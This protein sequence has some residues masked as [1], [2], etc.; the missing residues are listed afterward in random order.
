MTAAR[1]LE[2]PSDPAWEAFGRS[3]AEAELSI[4]RGTPEQAARLS[5]GYR[6]GRFSLEEMTARIEATRAADR[7]PKTSDAPIA[8]GD[9]R[10]PERFWRKV[11]VDPTTGCWLWTASLTKPGYG[12]WYPTG[13]RPTTAHRE[14][15][16]VL[17]G[18]IPAGL[19]LDHLCRN[20]ACC[21][22]AHLEPVTNRE[23]SL[24]SPHRRLKTHCDQGH[25][26]TPEN[27]RWKNNGGPYPT[28]GCRACHNA[29]KKRKATA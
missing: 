10:L 21:N 27:T 25:E 13:Q 9:P 12:Q 29:P 1:R 11:A 28:R 24:R 23:N 2:E 3:L 16:R 4:R 15:Y 20:R 6:S 5:Y 7:I 26:Y 8:L 18:E 14:A 22:P 19:Q 17:V